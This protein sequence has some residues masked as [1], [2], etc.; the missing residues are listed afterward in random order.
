VLEII[1][2]NQPRRKTRRVWDNHVSQSY[3]CGKAP[4]AFPGERLGRERADIGL[5]LLPITETR[6]NP[7]TGIPPRP[8]GVPYV[9]P[10]Y[11]FRIETFGLAKGKVGL[12]LTSLGHM[13]CEIRRMSP[14]VSLRYICICGH[15][16][17]QVVH[18]PFLRYAHHRQ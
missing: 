1:K 2:T 15:S 9:V 6:A 11:G 14:K 4:S 13:P 8:L 5:S 10:E 3:A 16:L 18:L 7:A 17:S 12:P